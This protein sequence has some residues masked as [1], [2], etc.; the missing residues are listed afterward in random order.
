MQSPLIESLPYLHDSTCYLAKVRSLGKAVYIDSCA[1]LADG[2]RYDIIS[3]A[4]AFTITHNCG[5]KTAKIQSSSFILV[6]EQLIKF[7][8]L[9]ELPLNLPFIGG[10]IGYLGYEAGMELENVTPTAD[11]AIQ[12]ADIE[13]GWYEWAIVNDHQEKQCYLVALPGFDQKKFIAI[14]ASIEGVLPANHQH[15]PFKLNH[16]FE[17][18][19]SFDQY[20]TA[21]DKIIRYIHAGDCYQVNLSQQFSTTYT[22]DTWD[23]Y[24]QLRAA[25]PSPYSAY[26]ELD[27]GALLSLSPEQFISLKQRQVATHPIKGTRPRGETAHEDQALA[28]ALENSTKDRAENLMIVDLLRNDL[29]K[30]CVPGSITVPELFKLQS[31]SNV[32]HLVSSITG[33]VRDD[34][35]SIELL[36]GCFPGGSITGAPKKRAMEIIAELEPHSRSIYCGSIGYIGANGDMNLNIAI[37]TLLCEDDKIYCW[38][39]GGIVADSEVEMEYQESFD[40]IDRLINCLPLS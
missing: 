24:Q 14:K 15:A 9:E 2:G 16:A 28:H 32:H 12:L 10:F 40:K 36:T 3:A 6:R 38:G 11:S 23:A 35:D 37:R 20:K 34:A 8:H 33:T 17:S 39:G 27:S 21:F 30:S 22:G 31:F 4:P 1:N 19:T 5:S 13:L 18:N 7:N 26:M 25:T 29:G